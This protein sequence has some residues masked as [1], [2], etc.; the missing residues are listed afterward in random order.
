[1]DRTGYVYDPVYLRHDTGEHVEVAGRL[2]AII[3]RLEESGLAEHLVPVTPR[4]ATLEELELVHDG[5]YI[6]HI[7][8][9][10]ERGG[11]W[12]DVDTVISVGSYEAALYAAGGLIEA[13]S[14]VMKRE[15]SNAFALVRPPGHHALHDRAMGFCIFN[16]V[17][18]AAKAAMNTFKLDKIAIIDFDVHHG[19]G[20]QDSFYREPRVLYTSTHQ[21]PYY[22]GTGGIN[23]TGEGLGRGYTINIPLP[24][25]CGDAE[26]RQVYK[27]IIIP[28]VRRFAPQL[29]L[30]SA[31]YDTHRNDPL[32]MI[33]LSPDG[34]TWVVAAIKD[35]ADELCGGKLVLTL[36]GGYN[37]EA[38]A[39][40]VEA[41]FR[42]LMGE[43][44]VGS[45]EPPQ[46]QHSAP[47]I[48]PV[49]EGVKAVHGL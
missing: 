25:G 18:I 49:I 19:N 48:T 26:Y 5:K 23:E 31:G 20:T 10:A 6:R 2:E 4:L 47:D 46:L 44:V 39:T 7:R 30:V 24:A 43:N 33:E 29:I 40:A 9:V 42:V 21:Y 22:P 28:A 37:L 8:E 35:L 38:Q 13:V 17:A 36:E 45:P 15:V 41:T 16:N 11:G 27:Q 12:L 14:A 34:F 3:S 32:A 1:M